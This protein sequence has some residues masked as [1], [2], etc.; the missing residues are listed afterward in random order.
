MNGTAAND[1]VLWFAGV[2]FTHPYYNLLS[3]WNSWDDRK[4]TMYLPSYDCMDFAW[5]AFETIYG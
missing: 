3:A 2:N 4:G 1:F 5:E